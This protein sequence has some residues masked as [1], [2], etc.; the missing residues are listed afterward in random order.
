MKRIVT[1]FSL[2]L[3]AGCGPSFMTER[4]YVL[5]ACGGNVENVPDAAF[6]STVLAMKSNRWLV[7]QVDPSR[8]FVQGEACRGQYC[9]SV[10]GTVQAN[11]QVH[12]LRTPEQHVGD[13]DLLVSWMAR[14]Q[15]RYN[16]YCAQTFESLRQEMRQNG[17][18]A[19]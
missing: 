10:D 4:P 18:L 5:K 3:L 17:Y 19:E 13:T 11:G 12:L 8:R 15:K 9:V 2:L 1:L 7:R 6:Y 16:Q 14:L